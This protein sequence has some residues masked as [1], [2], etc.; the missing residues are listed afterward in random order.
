MKEQLG[1]DGRMVRGVALVAVV[2]WVVGVSSCP[3]PVII[4]RECLYVQFKK[5]V[6]ARRQKVGSV[7]ANMPHYYY[8][9]EKEIMNL[10]SSF[11]LYFLFDLT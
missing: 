6:E 1:P 11:N 5:E 2:K 9:S 3:R 7:H 4:S 8:K 10:C